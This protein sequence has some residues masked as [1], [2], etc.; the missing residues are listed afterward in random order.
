[1]ADKGRV[2]SC[3]AVE[4]RVAYATRLREPQTGAEEKRL[5]IVFSEVGAKTGTASNACGRQAG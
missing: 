2:Q 5:I 4:K 3:A 1:M